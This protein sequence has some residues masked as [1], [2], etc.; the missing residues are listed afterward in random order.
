MKGY[1]FIE[2]M[3]NPTTVS[4]E[5]LIFAPRQYIEHARV[6]LRTQWGFDEISR[7]TTVNAFCR[8]WVSE[9]G[10]RSGI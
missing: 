4:H 3:K 8:A 9:S 10:Q 1:S 5:M 6:T 2:N 7:I